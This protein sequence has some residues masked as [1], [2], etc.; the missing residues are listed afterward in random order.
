MYS[1]KDICLIIATYNRS[2][3]LRE[4]FKQSRKE[5][6]KI[7]EI[8]IVD[9]S[10]DDKTKKFIKSIKDK[11][12]RYYYR[13]K[14]SLTD[15]RNF[16]ATKAKGKILVFID[17][18]AT[19]LNGYFQGIIDT[20]NKFPNAMGV[21]GFQKNTGR[22]LFDRLFRKIFFLENSLENNAGV[23]SAYGAIYPSKLDKTI[24]SKWLCGHDMSYHKDVFDKYK[25][26]FD[27]NLGG[28]AL[29]EDFDFS[30]RVWKIN[31]GGLY[32]TP[33]ALMVHR[34]SSTSRTPTRKLIY[35][36]QIN[37]FYF[38]Y[39]N[40]NSSIYEKLVFHL[41]L[42]GLILANIVKLGIHLKTTVTFFKSLIFCFSNINKIKKGKIKELY[43]KIDA[44][45]HAKACGLKGA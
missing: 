44:P 7:G 10:N 12:I 37:H 43:Q 38:N 1:L 23:V 40:F 2:D 14:P 3:D 27:E 19:L 11:E 28:Y 33:K 6:S 18:D 17:D 39:K 26:K 16:G 29:G 9:Q 41:A 30:Y 25:L 8:L 13:E 35:M 4:T 42:I 21:S 20:F 15:A 34:F 5:F 22:G 45:P 31:K 36:N 32:M 24:Q